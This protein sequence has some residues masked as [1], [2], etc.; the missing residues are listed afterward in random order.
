M[1]KSVF[2]QPD[3]FPNRELSWLEFNQRILGEARDRKNPLFERMKFL[4]ITA[5]NL[6]EFF[7]V[8][9]ASLKDMVN[10]GYQKKD[11]AGMTAQEQ[12]RALNEKMQAFGWA[13]VAIAE[14]GE[15]LEDWQGDIIEPDELESAAYKFVD[16]YREGGEMH[17][18]GGVAY[19]IESV[20]FTEE[21]MAAMGIP[22]GTLPVGWWIGF[23]L[24]DADVWEKVKD[25]TYSMF[26][27][28]GEAERVKVN[29]E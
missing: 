15:T 21:K 27:I 18:R 4:S 16:L 14:N 23:Q 6:D 29:N 25:G 8:R 9:I 10:A 20:V 17:E 26:S 19:L 12:L 1:N 13:S 5:S 7:M 11:I 3:N 2:D 24:T 22:E 28:E